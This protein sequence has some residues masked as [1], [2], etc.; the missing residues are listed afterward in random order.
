MLI[1]SVDH[2]W[3][4]RIREL[5]VAFGNRDREARRF[6]RFDGEGAYPLFI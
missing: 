3:R 4:L 6:S 2:R 1:M 5:K